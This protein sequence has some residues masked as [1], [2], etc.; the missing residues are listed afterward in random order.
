MDVYLLDFIPSQGKE[1]A[2]QSAKIVHKLSK[3]LLNFKV[4]GE[5]PTVIKSP[6]MSIVVSREQPSQMGNKSLGDGDSEIEMPPSDE[7]FGDTMKNSSFVDAEVN[8]YI[9]IEALHLLKPWVCY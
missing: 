6:S 5:A 9:G 8:K 4:P 3:N 2:K 1:I 7:I